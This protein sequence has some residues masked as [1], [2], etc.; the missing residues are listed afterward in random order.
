MPNVPP[1]QSY[2]SVHGGTK[3]HTQIHIVHLTP[4]IYFAYGVT[5]L[6]TGIVLVETED[7]PG[8][9][10]V[11]YQ[12][13]SH[14]VRPY[15]QVVHHSGE[16]LG[17]ELPVRLDARAVGDEERDVERFVAVVSCRQATQQASFTPV[18]SIAA[19]HWS[20]CPPPPP[21]KFKIT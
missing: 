5:N 10:V 17:D 11:L 3:I 9:R 2:A 14:S 16:E 4:E 1:W 18:A 20:A 15:D 19:V 12:R 21:L 7:K 13:N 8:R 6:R